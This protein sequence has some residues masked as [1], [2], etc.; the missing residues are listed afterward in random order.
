MEKKQPHAGSAWGSINTV[1]VNKLMRQLIKYWD[2]DTPTND[3]IV[4]QI[5]RQDWPNIFIKDNGEHKGRGVFT[6]ILGIKMGTI[7]CDYHGDLIKGSEGEKRMKEYQMEDGSFMMFVKTDQ[8]KICV[9]ACRPCSCHSRDAFFETKGS[10]INHSS[11][12]ANLK[13]NLQ[14]LVHTLDNRKN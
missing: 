1:R 12:R 6:G 13:V 4:D 9:Y 2:D 11:A 7:V 8:G 3:D 14:E 10:L 5:H